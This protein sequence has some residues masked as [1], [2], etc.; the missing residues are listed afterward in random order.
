MSAS[1]SFSLKSSNE[2][3]RPLIRR[4]LRDFISPYR[5]Q[6]VMAFL[7][8]LSGA[9]ATTALPYSLKPVFDHVFVK[10]EMNMLFWV[11]SM[12][13]GAFIV[14][15]ASAYGESVLM[16]FVGQKIIA[17]IQKKLFRHLVKADLFYFHTTPSG[18]LL[19]RFTNDVAM[20]RNAMATTLISLGKDFLTLVFLVGLMFYMDATLAAIAFV[21]FPTAVLP[22]LKIGKRMRKV[23]HKTQDQHATLSSQL[24]QIFQGIRVVKAYGMEAAE[25][26]RIHSIID[27]VFTL[28]YK[29]TRIKSATHPIVESLGG[30]AI[31]AVIAYGGWQVIHHD[32]TAGDFIAFIASL[33]LVYE[34]LKRLSNLNANLQEGLA[35]TAR[36]FAMLDHPA[37]I[38]D[39]AAS[40]QGI[41]PI[42][43]N[44][45]FENVTFTYPQHDDDRRALTNLSFTVPQGKTVAFVGASGAGKSTI[46]NLLARF[47]DVTSGSIMLDGENIKDMSLAALRENMALV[48]QEVSLFDRTVAQNIAYSEKEYS[49]DEIIAA[50]K[51]AAAHDFIMQLPHGYETLVGENGV[52]LSGGQRQRIVI[53]RAMLKNAPLLLLDEATSALD[54]ESERQ[55]QDA[56]SS[57]MHGRTTLIVAHRLSTIV[58]AD[59]IYVLDQ[60][61]IIEAGQHKELLQQD[62][63]YAKLWY[64]QTQTACVE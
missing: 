36:V 15:G 55:I 34:P 16:T 42:K 38:F 61:C 35:A 12:V 44:V 14:K 27:H 43:G 46:I 63:S 40:Q 41:E 18:E 58:N 28:T 1:E 2:S 62:G 6:L 17:D 5:R 47:Y 26:N 29:A 4:L 23:T 7:C 32:R 22:I 48:S 59:M 37:E 64:K 11:S 33:L 21:V 56:L 20:M 10:G 54:S 53:A 52:T 13:L 31:V 25:S 60:G 49:Q 50:A 45:C 19:S 8:M 51:A 57:L 9:L 24:N 3:S 30:V 39:N